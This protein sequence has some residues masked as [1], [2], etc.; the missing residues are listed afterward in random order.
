LKVAGLEGGKV[1]TQISYFIKKFMLIKI[2][3]YIFMYQHSKYFLPEVEIM[4]ACTH[5]N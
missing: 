4:D 1:Y 3:A 2:V 5:V